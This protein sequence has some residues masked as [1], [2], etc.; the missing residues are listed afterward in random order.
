[1][2]LHEYSDP[3]DSDVVFCAGDRSVLFGFAAQFV[4]ERED[5]AQCTD[6]FANVAGWTRHSL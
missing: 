6:A 3:A 1:V 4:C 5:G 2:W